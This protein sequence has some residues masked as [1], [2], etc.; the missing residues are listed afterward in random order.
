MGDA[1][2]P[3]ISAVLFLLGE[4]H[5][6]LLDDLRVVA[7]LRAAAEELSDGDMVRLVCNPVTAG[8][9]TV[10]ALTTSPST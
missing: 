8:T 1:K 5:F 9:V 4:P 10:P 7:L 2:R 6:L 3:T